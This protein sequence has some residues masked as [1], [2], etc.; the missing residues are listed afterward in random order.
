MNDR[1]RLSRTYTAYGA[2]PRKHRAWRAENPGNVAIRREL[3]DAVA[4]IGTV[5][6]P[7]AERVL[8]IGCGSGWWLAAVAERWPQA[9]LHGIDPLNERV[10]A[11]QARVPAAGIVAGD[12]REVAY[13]PASFDAVF[14][15]TVLSSLSSAEAAVAVATIAAALVTPGG[16]LVIW[17]PRVPNPLNR[18][19]TFVSERRLRRALGPPE[20]AM[21]LTVL[22]PLARRLG[23]R[24][25]AGYQRLARVP[26]LRTHRLMWWTPA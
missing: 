18:H 5:A 6:L 22:P 23:S 17:E 14:L 19:T 8:D 15:F 13:P 2:S 20:G 9:E 7:R 12:V 10:K 4:E 21:S 24:T 25:A 1:E 3:A 26:V 11:A 16:L